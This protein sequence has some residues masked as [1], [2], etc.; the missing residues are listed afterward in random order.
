MADTDTVALV[1]AVADTLAVDDTDAELLPVI[2]TD[3]VPDCDDDTEGDAPSDSD[4]V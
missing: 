1:D 4:A 2:D 3:D